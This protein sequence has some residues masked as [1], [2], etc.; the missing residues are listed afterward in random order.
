MFFLFPL[1]AFFADKGEEVLIFGL[2]ARK[3]FAPSRVALGIGCRTSL[4][5]MT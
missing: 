4:P 2:V 5:L 3:S 1:F